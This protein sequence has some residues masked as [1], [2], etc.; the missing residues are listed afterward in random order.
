MQRR[1]KPK[2]RNRSL[3]ETYICVCVL[4]RVALS[5]KKRLWEFFQRLCIDELA[6][7]SMANY[8][9]FMDIGVH[10]YTWGHHMPTHRNKLALQNYWKNGMTLLLWLKE[11]MFPSPASDQTLPWGQSL[12]I[13]SECYPP[14]ALARHHQIIFLNWLLPSPC[15]YHLLSHR[16]EW[17]GQPNLMSFFSCTHERKIQ[18]KS[19]P[20]GNTTG[21][22]HKHLY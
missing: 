4:L 17:A 13:F 10:M 5:Y 21:I 22:C 14:R 16:T 12:I 19:R 8:G 15:P 2:N 6:T 9:L 11:N 1:E 20:L 3:A 7:Q 18:A